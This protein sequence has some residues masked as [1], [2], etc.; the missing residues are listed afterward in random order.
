MRNDE[1]DPDDLRRM[2]RV[3]IGRRMRR[4]LAG[5][6]DTIVPTPAWELHCRAVW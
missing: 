5:G 1:S 3:D 2:I 6:V 4:W